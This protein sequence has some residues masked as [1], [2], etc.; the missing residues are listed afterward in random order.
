MLAKESV[1]FENSITSKSI[2]SVYF[3]LYIPK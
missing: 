2:G 3:A 1:T